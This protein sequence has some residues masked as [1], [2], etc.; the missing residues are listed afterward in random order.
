MAVHIADSYFKAVQNQAR[1]WR[2]SSGAL[3]KSSVNVTAEEQTGIDPAWSDDDFAQF[4]HLSKDPGEVGNRLVYL[5]NKNKDQI[6][7]ECEVRSQCTQSVRLS[8]NCL[9]LGGTLSEG[10]SLLCTRV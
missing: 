7:H 1:G 5:I 4:V 3:S 2:G 10:A 6:P 9:Q 8:H